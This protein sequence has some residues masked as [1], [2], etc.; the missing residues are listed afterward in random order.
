MNALAEAAARFYR[1]PLPN[2][3]SIAE[4]NALAIRATAHVVYLLG[5]PPDEATA[6]LINSAM[7]GSTDLTP[8]DLIREWSALAR[9]TWPP[10]LTAVATSNSDRDPATLAAAADPVL[11]MAAC[12]EWAGAARLPPE[13]SSVITAAREALE[14]GADEKSPGRTRVSPWIYEH[15][16]SSPNVIYLDALP[17]GTTFR[18]ALV[19]GSVQ[20]T[21]FYCNGL[22]PTLEIYANRQ[23]LNAVRAATFSGN[24]L[25]GRLTIDRGLRLGVNVPANEGDGFL[26][27]PVHNSADKRATL[28]AHA[29]GLFRV[30]VY[31]ATGES[32]QPN[33]TLCGYLPSALIEKQQFDRFFD[34]RLAPTL[35]SQ[36]WSIDQSRHREVLAVSVPLAVA[37]GV[38]KSTIDTYRAELSL[39]RGGSPGDRR[40]IVPDVLLRALPRPHPADYLDRG[41]I[42]VHIEMDERA[43]TIEFYWVDADSEFHHHGEVAHPALAKAL[44]DHRAD[45]A[46][47]RVLD[48]EEGRLR[49]RSVLDSLWAS[50]AHWWDKAN[51][52]TTGVTRMWYSI[53]REL[54]GAP[55]WFLLGQICLTEVVRAQ[56][57]TLA[58]L[59]ADAKADET[60]TPVHDKPAAYVDVFDAS[61]SV[62]RLVEAP[63][64]CRAIGDQY[65]YSRSLTT[66]EDFQ[67]SQA[68]VVHVSCHGFGAGDIFSN[69]IV[70]SEGGDRRELYA[71]DLLESPRMLQSRLI[72]FDVCSA[73][74]V[75]HRTTV[76]HEGVSVAQ[77]AVLHGAETA[78]A[79]EWSVGDLAG[80]LYA[81]T[82]HHL[83]SQ[84]LSP[85]KSLTVAGEYFFGQANPAAGSISGL[86]ER[87]FGDWRSRANESAWRLEGLEH[88]AAFEVHGRPLRQSRSGSG[89]SE[90]QTAGISQT[91]QMARSASQLDRARFHRDGDGD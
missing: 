73:G 40:P 50:F 26:G 51:A 8:G 18:N 63:A 17:E 87:T 37:L 74:S 9:S 48:T 46:A 43:R 16:A 47:R 15:L 67:T 24:N 81:V 64:E 54:S 58:A 76:F 10:E 23:E 72:F 79:A 1:L 83:Y 44:A 71:V 11:S 88:L 78:V 80:A 25:R 90:Q 61:P 22:L 86:L 31:D 6:R 29:L 36:F 70:L 3:G 20:R 69:R 75:S 7:Q 33:Y 85:S 91:S 35:E 56:S 14:E 2:G 5:L 12:L 30:C 82:F 89:V 19:A 4:R 84:G 68:D 53:G 34:A 60:D 77:A 62:D 41:E 55:L 21:A 49:I 38:D 32:L 42:F 52:G 27:A 57:L 66:P 13:L 59:V 65:P 45:R 28:V 39:C